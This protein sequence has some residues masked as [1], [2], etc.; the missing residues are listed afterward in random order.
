MIANHL[1]FQ[2]GT[3]DTR[4]RVGGAIRVGGHAPW[5]PWRAAGTGWPGC[6]RAPNYPWRLERRG[7][8]VTPARAR[9]WGAE[10]ARFMTHF[11]A[12]DFYNP[13]VDSRIYD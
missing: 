9:E 4:A 8:S 1:S 2:K 11:L 6:S 12:A 5:R 13:S 7:S 3:G 10:S